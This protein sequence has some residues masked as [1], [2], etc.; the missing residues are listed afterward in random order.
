MLLWLKLSTVLQCL[1][2]T[3]T[4]CVQFEE[5]GK[6]TVKSKLHIATSIYLSIIYIPKLSTLQVHLSQNPTSTTCYSSERVGKLEY[7]PTFLQ[8]V[9]EGF[10]MPFP[11]AGRQVSLVGEGT[12]ESRYSFREVSS[13]QMLG[14]LHGN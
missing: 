8:P 11:T 12:Q 9:S 10:G 3:E 2:S 13:L 1:A 4:F 7:H 14:N 6:A 5:G